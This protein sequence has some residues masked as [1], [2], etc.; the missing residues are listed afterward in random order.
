MQCVCTDPLLAVSAAEAVP[1]V[2]PAALE[3]DAAVDAPLN[4]R[5]SAAVDHFTIDAI[6]VRCAIGLDLVDRT[7][8]VAALVHVL[9]VLQNVMHNTLLYH[10]HQQQQ[11]QQQ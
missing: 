5:P 11:Q 10:H 1:V 2:V 4:E 8:S 9:T 3:T 6:R 7:H